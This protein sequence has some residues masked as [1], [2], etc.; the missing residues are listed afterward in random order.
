VDE[1][2]QILI[3]QKKKLPEGW[4][5][6][7]LQEVCDIYSGSTPSRNEQK[8]WNGNILWATPTDLSNLK[9]KY[10]EE[11]ENKIT[12]DGYKNCSTKLLPV[13]TVLFTS[14]ASIGNVAIAK[15]EICTNQGFKNF[16]CKSRVI[17]EFLYY[18]L[19]FKKKDIEKIA[20]GAT[21]KE[22]SMNIIKKVRIL[23]PPILEQQKI[24]EK[25]D[26]QIACIEMMKKETEKQQESADV[27]FNSIINKE[28]KI[29]KFNL[30]PGWKKC[31]MDELCDLRT[32]GTPSKSHLEYFGGNIKWIVSG[33]VNN[34]FI[35]DVKG[36]ITELGKNN[37]P[38]KMLPKDSV[39]IALNG[40]GKTRGTVSVL[41]T[42]AT[43]NQSV[44]A[45]IPK[46]RNQID[47]M[48]L[49]YYL[50]GCYQHLRNL[51]GDNERS[52]LSMR[53]LKPF[54]VIFPPIDDQRKIAKKL[55]Q[56]Q[57]GI[58][59]L[60]NNIQDQKDTI[61][62]L[63]NSIFNQVFGQYAFLEEA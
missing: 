27:I 48:F 36:R 7:E 28:L 17:P 41:K 14:R 52:G 21:F 15:K 63:S 45:F 16:V 60:I 56:K 9:S 50:K 3:E 51:T 10:I 29:S 11:T 40:Q 1:M 4:E 42:E 30:P 53:V 44:I 22:V 6:V 2:K 39:L 18:Q 38:T 20:S 12:E 61:F 23:L 37:S 25:L 26:K 54:N 34:E 35:Y 43:C 58:K 62:S 59:K 32:G 8:Y 46:D 31:K 19:K 33:D 57:E 5:I 47:Y 55:Q 13:G 49:F 24:I